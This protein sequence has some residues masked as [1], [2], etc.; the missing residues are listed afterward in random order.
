M[1]WIHATGPRKITIVYCVDWT[2]A[3]A[4]GVTIIEK[5]SKGAEFVFASDAQ[6]SKRLFNND[7][8]FSSYVV[9]CG[10]YDAESVPRALKPRKS[11]DM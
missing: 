7:H 6:V 11:N 3:R 4:K 2:S 8:S 5:I 10:L 1:K 9:R